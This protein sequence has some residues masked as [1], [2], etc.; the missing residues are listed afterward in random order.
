MSKEYIFYNLYHY[1]DNILNL[2]FLFNITPILKNYNIIIKYYYNS[3]YIK[4]RDEL[5]IYKND[6]IH[7][8]SIENITSDNSKNSIHMWIGHYNNFNNISYNIFDTFFNL[9]YSNILNILNI[10]DTS[11]TTSLY[12]D[13]SYLLDIYNK[14]DNKYHDIEILILN[15]VPQSGQYRE[16]NKEEW[17]KM[18]IYL[19]EKYNI[20][21]T[22]YVNDNIKC[23]MN[24]KLKIQDIGAISTH[25]KYIIGVH[26][27]TITGCYNKYTQNN[28]KKWFIFEDTLMVKHE[29]INCINNC[30]YNDIYDNF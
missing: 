4:N 8:D 27:G 30:K 24:D 29:L 22:T 1:G 6:V 11:I 19:N 25:A 18:C 13:E 15:S 28:V 7:I 2:K 10:S 12:Q 9:Y 23:T 5:L 14:L 20:V 21:V 3:A 16:Y 17:D 26:S